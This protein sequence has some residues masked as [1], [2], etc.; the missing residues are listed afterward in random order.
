MTWLCK[1]V[2]RF[3]RDNFK[4]DINNELE[5]EL[6]R[7]W[8]NLTVEAIKTLNKPFS[9][10]KQLEDYKSVKNWI[11]YREESSRTGKL[12]LNYKYHLIY[13]LRKYC[14]YVS[15]N[16][17]E[18]VEFSMKGMFN[19]NDL[20]SK[21]L[22]SMTTAGA[23][24]YCSDVKSFLSFHKI[25]LDV[26]YPM[27]KRIEKREITIDE[28]RKICSVAEIEDK[29]WILANSYMGLNVN[30][31]TLLCIKIFY[32]DNWKI[33]K[34]IYPVKIRKEVSGK[35]YIA[36][37][38]ADAMHELKKF[39][40]EKQFSP[41]D[42]PW[43]HARPTVLNYRFTKYARKCKIYERNNQYLSPNSVILRLRR[44]LREEMPHELA[45]FVLG[46][47]PYKYKEVNRPWD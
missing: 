15:L 5:I 37:I 10:H 35:D 26:S 43:N 16:P 3:S 6:K 41:Q 8:I 17:D 18:I 42:R 28:I 19:P 40:E 21:F 9:L 45:C 23:V 44:I 20:F 25:A 36:F 7:T 38:G 31:V 2:D 32:V 24:P 4:V 13:H 22:E 11:R 12:Q 47:K 14:N 46:I 30:A 33:E 1:F 29:S 27:Y 39:F 34:P